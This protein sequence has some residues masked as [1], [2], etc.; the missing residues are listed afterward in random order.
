MNQGQRSVVSTAFHVK[1]LTLKLE[2]D[3]GPNIDDL[4]GKVL[5]VLNY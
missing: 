5:G 3:G 1:L 2:L 4:S